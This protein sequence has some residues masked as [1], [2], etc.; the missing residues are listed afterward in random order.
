MSVAA[1]PMI[2]GAARG[3]PPSRY[4]APLGKRF[5]DQRSK[6]HPFTPRCRAH[7]QPPPLAPREPLAAKRA[8]MKWLHATTRFP[9]DSLPTPATLPHSRRRPAHLQHPANP[10]AGANQRARQIRERFEPRRIT[11]VQLDDPGTPCSGPAG[12]RQTDL[13]CAS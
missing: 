6:C 12:I 4:R 11:H 1:H 7:Y 8:S 3:P 13:L 9:V 5:S 10:V 2:E